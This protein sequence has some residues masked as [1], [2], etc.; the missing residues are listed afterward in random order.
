[1]PDHEG[2]GF[3]AQKIIFGIQGG[4]LPQKCGDV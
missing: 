1:M 3:Q 2:L 4:K